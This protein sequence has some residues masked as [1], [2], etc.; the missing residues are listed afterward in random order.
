MGQFPDGDV[1]FWE[2]KALKK[3][4]PGEIVHMVGWECRG[5]IGIEARDGW[6]SE[7]ESGRRILI[8]EGEAR[9]RSRLKI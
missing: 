5:V 1:G 9:K 2:D 4:N 6:C 3:V 8:H 7:C